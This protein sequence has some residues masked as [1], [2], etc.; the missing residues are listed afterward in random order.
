M[1][2]GNNIIGPEKIVIDIANKL[3]IIGSYAVKAAVEPRQ[4]GQ[5]TRRTIHSQT[6]LIIEPHSKKLIPIN[7][8]I[9]PNNRDFIF[10]PKAQSS[11]SMYAHLV[12][13]TI[14]SVL[15]ANNTDYPVKIP[16]K[17]RL[18]TL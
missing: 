7:T 5:F 2:I 10:E 11:L 6:L 3:T 12:D 1:L 13:S 18:G 8:P 14:T 4:R 16:R 17:S 9:V 15:V